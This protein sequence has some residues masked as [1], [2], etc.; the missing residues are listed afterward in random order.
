MNLLVFL[1]RASW[2]SVVIAALTGSISGSCS[3]F[4]I[5]FI[6]STI[7]SNNPATNQLIWGFIGLA[8]VT[9]L[10]SLIS[11]FVLVSLSQEAVYK[12]RL[13]LS[14]L[15]LGCPLR[16]LEELGANRLLATLTDDIQAISSAVFDIP[17]LCINIALIFG[18]LVYLFWLSW[19]VFLVTVTF[20]AVAIAIVQFLITK[21]ERLF[22]LS[23]NEQDKLFKN[24]RAITDGIKELKLHTS[25][26]EAF[27]TEELQVTAALSRD[28]RVT[29]LRLLA[30]AT[31]LGELLFF[32]LM[33]LLIFALPKQ[34]TIS[35]TVL[36]GYVLT[37]TYL[38]RPLQSILQILP[39]FSQARVALQKIDTLGLSLASNAET[40]LSNSKL[41][42]VFKKIELRNIV[43]AYHTEQEE[44]NF[45]IG[46]INLTF[47][48]NE[49][50]FIVGG[51]GSGK[52]TLAKLITGLYIP[53]AGKLFLDREVITEQNRE[54][55][56]QLFATVFSDFYLFE[57]ILGINLD[58]LDVQAQEYLSKLHLEHKV[59]VKEGILSTIE[60]S[61]GQRKRL[62]LLT[63]YLEDRPIYLFDEWASDQ[64]PFFR[65]IFY[66]QLLPEL[67][68]RGKTVMVI[69]HDDRYF[70]LADRVI[71]LEYG[72]IV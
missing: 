55:Y 69:S 53:E 36:S 40:I 4:L 9:L 14:G 7:S 19:A 59:Q 37:I 42:P 72:K 6:N 13:R 34:A 56:R 15:I 39:A 44:S 65:E 11:Q 25:R 18:C 5:A 43:H 27:L 49:L 35:T 10:T 41:Q 17:L 60:L 33:G 16:H 68:H 21:A 47:H 58:N 24:F 70:Y 26:R 45:T 61:Q 57:R 71:K 64:D 54:S 51:N 46:P 29:S 66:K 8:F 50:V 22:K 32:I 20:L 1:L 30:I 38:L 2:I 31:S 3:A 62:A 12:L 48:Q 23:R 52:S 63:A 67:K 28:Y